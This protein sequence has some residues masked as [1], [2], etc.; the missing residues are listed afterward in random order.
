[1]A[2][3]NKIE[4]LGNLVRENELK[5]LPGGAVVLENAICATEIYHNKEGEKVEEPCFVD[6]KVWGKQAE[7]LDKYTSKGDQILIAGRLKQEKWVAPGGENRSK[8]VVKVREFQFIR[9]KGSQQQDDREER[10]EQPR[11]TVPF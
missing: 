9:T 5:H 10:E 3:W 11:G 2:N 4:L 6:F 1:M 8:L 7:T